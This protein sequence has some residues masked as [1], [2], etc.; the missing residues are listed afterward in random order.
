MRAFLSVPAVLGLALLAG[1]QGGAATTASTPQSL[2]TGNSAP[3][4]TGVPATAVVAG[5]AYSFT[6]SANDPNGDPISFTIQNKPAWATFSTTSGA[7]GGTPTTAQVGTYPN[8][9]ISASD[10]KTATSLPA[11]SVQV[12]AVNQP[13][14]ISGVPAAS[15]AAGQVYSFTPSATDPEGDVLT[16]SITAKP[17]W[18]NFSTVTGALTGTPSSAQ[19]GTSCRQSS[20]GRSAVASRTICSR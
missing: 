2:T 10:G 8:I 9:V 12:S 5:T 7:L 16:F 15:V 19:T 17:A 3:T 20:S 4:I 11:F 14:T 1:C 18:A 13:P 6:P